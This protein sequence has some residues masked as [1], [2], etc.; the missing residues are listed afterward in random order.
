M[1]LNGRAVCGTSPAAGAVVRGTAS[2][3]LNETKKLTPTDGTE[4]APALGI[5]AFAE[6]TLVA[7]GQRASS[8]VGC[9]SSSTSPH[10]EVMCTSTAEIGQRLAELRARSQ[11]NSREVVNRPGMSGDSTSW[12]GWSHVRW[13]VEEVSAGAAGAGGADGR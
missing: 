13:F 3:S 4:L 5:G 10:S 12:E 8:N 1:I 11:P 7:A 6:K 9:T 2:P